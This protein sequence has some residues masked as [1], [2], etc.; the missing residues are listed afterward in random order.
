[1]I[2]PIASMAAASIFIASRSSFCSRC[3]TSG[4][5]SAMDLPLLCFPVGFF[6]DK[7]NHHLKILVVLRHPHGKCF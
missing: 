1:M 3:L 5:Q 6:Q 7:A 2:T 4:V